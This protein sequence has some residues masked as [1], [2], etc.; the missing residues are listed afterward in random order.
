MFDQLHQPIDPNTY[1]PVKTKMLALLNARIDYFSSLNDFFF[2]SDTAMES[3]NEELTAIWEQGNIQAVKQKN[4]EIFSLLDKTQQ[5]TI[6]GTDLRVCNFIKELIELD[7]NTKPLRLMQVTWLIRLHLNAFST[8]NKVAR[9]FQLAAVDTHQQMLA[10]MK[11][12][13]QGTLLQYYEMIEAIDATIHGSEIRFYQNKKYLNR[14]SAIN[15]KIEEITEIK[16]RLYDKKYIDCSLSGF[17][18]KQKISPELRKEYETYK[19]L[20]THF[21][22]LLV[23]I[24]EVQKNIVEYSSSTFISPS[25]QQ[26]EL[27]VA[28]IDRTDDHGKKVSSHL[29]D[30]IQNAI[31][32]DVQPLSH[33]VNSQLS[34][35]VCLSDLDEAFSLLEGD[36]VLD[37]LKE[38]FQALMPLPTSKK[39]QHPKRKKPTRKKTLVPVLA[40]EPEPVQS[41]E[42]E[43][44]VASSPEIQ[45][46]AQTDDKKA[47]NNITLRLYRMQLEA[48]PS[49][50]AEYL[51]PVK[52]ASIKDELTAMFENR[53]AQL[54]FSRLN[55][56]L[57]K[58][59]G[60]IRACGSGSNHFQIELGNTVG[61][62]CMKHK[63]GHTKNYLSPLAK[64]LVLTIFKKAGLFEKHEIQLNWDSLAPASARRHAV[65]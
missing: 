51:K 11:S 29:K 4:K 20:C 61:Y 55:K 22:S 52:T 23:N 10:E 47:L 57:V 42:L 6:F 19:K 7:Q 14:F 40:C 37:E 63:P 41:E 28:R 12:L 64:N 58:L 3:K 27:M 59:N 35:L 50:P 44:V 13:F 31:S 15:K 39:A 38:R 16:N 32:A 36:T 8:E 54:K 30:T 25:M 48:S 49:E 1:L 43:T 62:F 2:D 33:F 46:Q 60:S 65:N 21:D 17:G 18:K 5:M 45:A 56:L 34:S 26:L 53:E 9:L 24:K